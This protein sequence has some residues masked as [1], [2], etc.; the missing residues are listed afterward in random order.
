[1]RAVGPFCYVARIDAR[2]C[3]CGLEGEGVRG[4]L[5]ACPTNRASAITSPATKSLPFYARP[6]KVRATVRATTR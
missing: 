2:G 4:K 5:C 3:V 1:M 6:R